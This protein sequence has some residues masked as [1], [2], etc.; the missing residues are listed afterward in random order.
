[1]T[2]RPDAD[3]LRHFE[4]LKLPYLLLDAGRAENLNDIREYVAQRVAASDVL[5]TRLHEQ[6]TSE[7]A[8]VE[9]VTTASQGNFLYL[10]WLLRGITG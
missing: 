3:A 5:Q 7:Q 6:H 4:E 9:R 10:V 2:A 8:F 1:L